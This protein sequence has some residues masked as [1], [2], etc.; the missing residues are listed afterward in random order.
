MIQY[1]IIRLLLTITFLFP[2]FLT[3]ETIT[4]KTEAPQ[5]RNAALTAMNQAIDSYYTGSEIKTDEILTDAALD[6]T[7]SVVTAGVLP[8]G[9][10]SGQG[11]ITAVS[12][13]MMTKLKN[14][15]IQN[16]KNSTQIKTLIGNIIRDCPDAVANSI[17]R[18][19]LDL[20]K[21]INE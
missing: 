11:S 9:T 13:Q 10:V 15:T 8:P 5:N 12:Q 2:L 16:L 18:K 6:F 1:Y 14:G 3:A 7:S 21:R 19:L 4:V 17:Y 20:S